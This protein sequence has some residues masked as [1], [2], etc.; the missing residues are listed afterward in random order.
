VGVTYWTL[1]WLVGFGGIG[2]FG[3]GLIVAT[4]M[5]QHVVKCRDNLKGKNEV[6]GWVKACKKNEFWNLNGNFEL[7]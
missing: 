5:S 3:G 6:E 4:T 1:W 7:L 2:D